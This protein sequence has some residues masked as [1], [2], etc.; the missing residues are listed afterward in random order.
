MIRIP[1][2]CSRE[3]LPDWLQDVYDY[4]LDRANSPN[5]ADITEQDAEIWCEHGEDMLTKIRQL[6]AENKRLTKERDGWKKLS[7]HDY[8]VWQSDGTD[9]PE[10]LVCGVVMSAHQI[11]AILAERDA[12]QALV[13]AMHEAAVG[14]VRGP[15]AGVVEDVANVRTQRDAAVAELKRIRQLI[16]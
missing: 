3:S 8:W 5:D 12:A 15:I 13:A 1:T 11:R 9:H 2:M 7:R 10:S 6:T 16:D 4:C 14:E